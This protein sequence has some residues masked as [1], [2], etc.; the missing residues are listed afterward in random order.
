MFNFDHECPSPRHE[1]FAL[2][3]YTVPS[4]YGCVNIWTSKLVI[5]RLAGALAALRAPVTYFSK[6]LGTR[7]VAAFL[8]AELFRVLHSESNN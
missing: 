7:Y 6:L 4:Q 2:E 1:Q 3:V 8:P 5:F